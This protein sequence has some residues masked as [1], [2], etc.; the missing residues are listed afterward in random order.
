MTVG[1]LEALTT[2]DKL[3]LSAWLW[4]PIL[5]FVVTRLLRFIAYLVGPK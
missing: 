2:G 4:L 3:L 5:Y 1:E